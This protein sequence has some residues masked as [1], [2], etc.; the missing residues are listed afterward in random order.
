M[1]TYLFSNELLELE[2]LLNVLTAKK[3][4][5]VNGQFHNHKRRRYS[6][7]VRDIGTRSIPVKGNHT[8]EDYMR[9]YFEEQ[10][11]NTD[12]DQVNL[13]LCC[14]SIGDITSVIKVQIGLQTLHYFCGKMY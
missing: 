14:Y 2:Q 11:R 5:T 6:A 1:V 7:A 8:K 10:E 12:W 13:F 9:G 3:R 4:C